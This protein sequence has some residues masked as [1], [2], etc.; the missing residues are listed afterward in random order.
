M[1]LAIDNAC[2]WFAARFVDEACP[3]N[4]IQGKL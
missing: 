2:F 1:G 3:F 4:H